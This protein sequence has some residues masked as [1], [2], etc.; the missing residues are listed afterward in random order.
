MTSPRLASAFLLLAA[1][2]VSAGAQPLNQQ[3]RQ[4]LMGVGVEEQLGAYLPKDVAF[5]DEAGRRVTVGQYLNRNRPVVLSFVYHNCPMLCSFILDGLTDAMEVEKAVPGR[6]YD[7]LAVSFAAD[8]TPELARRAKEKYMEKLG[9]PEAA[10]GW[11]FLTGSEESITALAETVGF[12]Y[13]WNEATQEY[14]HNAVLVFI[15]PEGK[16]TRYLYGIQFPER[17]FRTALVEAG[18]GT[19]GSTLDRLL[20]YCVIYDPDS[21][22]YVPYAANIMKLGGLLTI[23]LMGGMLGLLWT[24]DR[25]RARPDA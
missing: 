13:R 20:L 14:A 7:V 19:I 5:V 11:H 23:L 18:K 17:S 3:E 9:R 16:V 24:R 6:D 22:S 25:R 12:Q 1:F 4:E 15:S 2:A 10:D 8:E 21:R